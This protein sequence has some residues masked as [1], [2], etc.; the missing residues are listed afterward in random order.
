MS[1]NSIDEK[2][3]SIV[4]E[5]W[6][7]FNRATLI[8]TVGA[9]LRS[10]GLWPLSGPKVSLLDYVRDNL[11]DEIR[12][13]GRPGYPTVF[14]LFPRDANL[15]ADID[16][17]FGPGRS[18]NSP[19]YQRAFWA[20]FVKPIPDG[21]RR[22]I[23]IDRSIF[24]D[25]PTAELPAGENFVEVLSAD[26]KL[27]P[28]ADRD[29]AALEHIADWAHRNKID[30]SR[31]FIRRKDSS[32]EPEDRRRQ[33]ADVSVLDKVLEALSERDLNRIQLPMDI[34]AKLRRH[35]V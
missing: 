27:D 23:D 6:E 29:A 9:E 32:Y 26:V 21:Y 20:A 35:R 16:R 8:S 7:Q 18:Q 11:S 30:L 19:R 25:A 28:S 12:V 22:F 33:T 1:T 10:A 4:R 15:G 3:L 2:L 14:G 5:R 31:F 34:V 17:Y 24:Q 13:E